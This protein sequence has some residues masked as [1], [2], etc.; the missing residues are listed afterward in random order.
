MW[1]R[2][3]APVAA[4]VPACT[5]TPAAVPPLLPR[6]QFTTSCGASAASTAA[7]SGFGS[8]GYRVGKLFRVELAR[9]GVRPEV[10]PLQEAIDH[11]VEVLE[12]FAPPLSKDNLLAA[13]LA[14]PRRMCVLHKHPLPSAFLVRFVR[15]RADD[16]THYVVFDHYGKRL[17]KGVWVSACWASISLAAS[18]KTRAGLGRGRASGGLLF[19]ALD[20]KPTSGPHIHCRPDMADHVLHVLHRHVVGML[21]AAWRSRIAVFGSAEDVLGFVD[22]IPQGPGQREELALLFVAT[23]LCPTTLQPLP[24]VDTAARQ[25]ADAIDLRQMTTGRRPCRSGRVVVVPSGV[26][27]WLDVHKRLVTSGRTFG[28]SKS[29]DVLTPPSST[30]GSDSEWSDEEGEV[31][32]DGEDTVNPAG[33]GQRELASDSAAFSAGTDAFPGPQGVAYIAVPA[34]RFA[35]FLFFS[36]L[37]LQGIMGVPF[38]LH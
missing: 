25:L 24:G 11:H 29:P 27:A 17:G 22:A 3:S 36:V 37:R 7:G 6:Q 21:A 9:N 34:G 33:L 16:G 31:P 4:A 15:A 18:A 35:R 32:E 19:K 10:Q 23:P 26:V 1:R 12:R 20:I 38:G 2:G 14:S 28:G 5:A 8:S 30:G 13:A